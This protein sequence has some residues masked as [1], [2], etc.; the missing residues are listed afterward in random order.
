MEF[1]KRSAP[2]PEHIEVSGT[3]AT[4]SATTGGWSFPGGRLRAFSADRYDAVIFDVQ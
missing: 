4:A 2:D 3:T 1:V